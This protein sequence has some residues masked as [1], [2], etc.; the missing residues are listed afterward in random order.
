[1][2]SLLNGEVVPNEDGYTLLHHLFANYVMC[3]EADQFF[4]ILVAGGVL[5]QLQTSMLTA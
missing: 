3:H 5:G 4:D 1:M 2:L